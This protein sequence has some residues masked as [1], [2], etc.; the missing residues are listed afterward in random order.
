MAP[1]RGRVGG[2]E[3]AFLGRPSRL[4]MHVSGDRGRDGVV[5]T[6]IG[7]TGNESPGFLPLDRQILL[8][9]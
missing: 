8:V 7:E 1:R 2:S 6:V 5:G 3:V 9:K 4:A